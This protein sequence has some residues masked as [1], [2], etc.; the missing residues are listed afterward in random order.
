[1][2]SFAATTSAPAA[3]APGNRIPN[4]IAPEAS[5]GVR[6]TQQRAEPAGH[7]PKQLVAHGVTEGVVDLLETVQVENQHCERFRLSARRQDRLPN[8]VAEEDPVRNPG[9][10]VVERL[11]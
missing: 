4:S 9:Q 8:A 10:F 11:M 7:L 6:V 1:M 3:S 2:H 5:E